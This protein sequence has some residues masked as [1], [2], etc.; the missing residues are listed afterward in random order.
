MPFAARGA[1]AACAVVV[2]AL[3]AACGGSVA[4]SDLRG[5][6]ATSAT[7]APAASPFCSAS[8]ASSAAIGPLNALVGRGNVNPNELARAVEEVRRAE[9]D[10]L[11]TAPSDIRADVRTTVDAVDAQLDALLAHGGDSAAVSADPALRARLAA[12]ELTAANQRLTAYLTRN[13]AGS[14]G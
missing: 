1:V 6:R 8:R 5:A 3:V 10:L 11:G 2:C 12:P 13:C 7:K 14:R 4:D 9:T